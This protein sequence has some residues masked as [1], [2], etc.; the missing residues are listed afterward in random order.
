MARKISTERKSLYYFGMALMAIGFIL[1]LSTFVTFAARFGDFTDFN[2]R[3]RSEMFRSVG[4]IVLLI[5][6]G[7]L[8]TIG[9]RGVAGSGLKLDPAQ[10]RSELEPFSRMAGG[11]AK[12]TLDEA[13]IDLSARAAP[14]VVIKCRSCR[15]LSP[16]DAKFCPQCGAAH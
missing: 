6:G 3:G 16:E 9:A 1:F 12:D 8:R 15:H 14:K 13:G 4:G 10:A 2:Q 5:V 7:I 11:M